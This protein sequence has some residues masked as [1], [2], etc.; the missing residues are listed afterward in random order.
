MSLHMLWKYESS[1]EPFPSQLPQ[2]IRWHFIGTFQS[3]KAKIL[4]CAYPTPSLLANRY[5][6]KHTAY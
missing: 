1:C 2:D 6:R 4:A 5:P 3:N